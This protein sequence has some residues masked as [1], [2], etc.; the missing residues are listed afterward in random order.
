M[1]SVLNTQR[2]IPNHFTSAFLTQDSAD[3]V[4]LLLQIDIGIAAYRTQNA[5]QMYRTPDDIDGQQGGIDTAPRDLRADYLSQ[6][7]I[8]KCHQNS[9]FDRRIT[10]GIRSACV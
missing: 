1:T 5:N 2:D 6:T 3:V 9:P 7:R 4:H 10:D 8:L